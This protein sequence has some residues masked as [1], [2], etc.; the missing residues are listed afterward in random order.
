MR[1]KWIAVAAM[2]GLQT[3]AAFAAPPAPDAASA[4]AFLKALYAQYAQTGRAEPFGVLGDREEVEYF[5]ASTLALLRENTR[6]LQGE[7]GDIEVD[8]VCVCQD[9]TGTKATIGD[10]SMTSPSAARATVSLAGGGR[11]AP[12]VVRFNLAFERGKWR[13]DDIGWKDAEY[14]LAS[15]R[16][17][18]IN[19]NRKLSAAA[20]H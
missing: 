19:E 17:S 9:S 15:Y 13:I 5:T 20:K 1:R 18:M 16:A 7:V 11:K 6:L 10:V 12:A 3:A 2:L 8:P 4:R 14:S